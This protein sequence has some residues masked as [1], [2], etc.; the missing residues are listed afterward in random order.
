MSEKIPSLEAKEVEAK[1]AKID[2]ILAQICRPGFST[3]AHGCPPQAAESI[4]TNGLETRNTD[5]SQTASAILS[6][7][8]VDDPENRRVFENPWPHRSARCLIILQ[9]PN[10]PKE[11]VGGF[12][13]FSR[14]FR[15]LPPEEKVEVGFQGVDKIHMIPPEF[16]Q[17]YVNLDILEFTL[18]PAFNPPDQLHVQAAKTIKAV[19]PRIKEGI[20]G[21]APP[22]SDDNNYNQ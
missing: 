9:I 22:S 20:I 12:T 18:N 1:E 14:V 3:L 13:Y 21:T 5:L 7:S 4:L 8:S 10:S 17:G 19:R 16:I 6:S 2:Q 15:E 11:G